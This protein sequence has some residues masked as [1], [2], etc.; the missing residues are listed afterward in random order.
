MWKSL[1]KL[2]KF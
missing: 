2:Q 1:A